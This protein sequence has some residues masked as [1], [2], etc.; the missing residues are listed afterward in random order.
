LVER[1][2][3][4]GGASESGR[5]LAIHV[6]DGFEHALAGIALFIAIAKFER[7]AASGRGA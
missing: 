2:L 3:V 1:C 6:P 5:Y 7:L 4:C